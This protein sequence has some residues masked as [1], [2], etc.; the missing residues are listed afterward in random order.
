[1]APACRPSNV[2][3]H[4]E[5]SLRQAHLLGRSTLLRQCL[6]SDVATLRSPLAVADRVCSSLL[7]LYRHPAWPSG[8]FAAWM[9]LRPKRLFRTASRA[10][11][12]YRL[13]SQWWQWPA[14]WPKF[15]N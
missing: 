9:A 2:M 1:M 8:V 12:V 3:N 7:W 4:P 5:I 6:R 14:A 10:W 11:W 15:L 13:A